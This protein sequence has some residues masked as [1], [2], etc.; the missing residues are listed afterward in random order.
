MSS[1]EKSLKEVF[2]EAANHRILG[3]RKTQW[4]EYISTSCPLDF[5]AKLPKIALL[6]ISQRAFVESQLCSTH[7]I[8]Q[9]MARNTTQIDLSRNVLTH[10]RVRVV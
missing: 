7:W 3:L 9:A 1:K 10:I 4:G 5:N 8:D 6:Y 2:R